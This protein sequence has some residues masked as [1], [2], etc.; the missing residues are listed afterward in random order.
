M[1]YIYKRNKRPS[2]TNHCD[3]FFKDAWATVKDGLEI[4]NQAIESKMQKTSI[5]G[6][7]TRSRGVKHTVVSKIEEDE[8]AEKEAKKAKWMTFA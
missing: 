3:P 5:G 4:L 1:G 8:Q 7:L 2:R 6:R